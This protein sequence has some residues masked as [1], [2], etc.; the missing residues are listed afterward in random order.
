MLSQRM[1]RQVMAWMPNTLLVY[2][3]KMSG[4]TGADSLAYTPTHISKCKTS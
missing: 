1:R 4:M 2:D 3:S